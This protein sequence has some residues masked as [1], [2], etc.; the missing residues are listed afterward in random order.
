M[1]GIIKTKGTVLE[2][3][4]RYSFIVYI[5][6]NK[7]KMNTSISRKMKIYEGKEFNIGDIVIIEYSPLDLTRGRIHRHS[8][9]L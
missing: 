5:E 6:K 3:I 9:T 4:D 8:F 7:L 2:I 1:S